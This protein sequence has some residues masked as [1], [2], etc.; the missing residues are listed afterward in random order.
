M[1]QALI[2]AL[3]Q[4]VHTMQANSFTALAIIALLW[5][6]QLINASVNYRLNTLGIVP[7]EIFGL[8]GIFTSP[9]LHGN[10]NHLFF[11]SI[12]L[13]FLLNLML[14]YGWDAFILYTVNI[15]FIGGLLTWFFGRNAT[16]IGCSGVIMGYMGFL[17]MQ[18]IHQR[19]AIA[20]VLGL[21]ALYY[22][23][24]ILL[25]LFP[26]GSKKTSWEGHVFGFVAGL[27]VGYGWFIHFL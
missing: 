9:F 12:P 4:L 14:A 10:A 27:M 11:N 6:I 19:T 17:M 8:S 24:S 15:A 3:G 1:F 22:C 25:S 2:T 7:R 13:F 21:V 16:H 18:A 5:F 20:L 23:S 26:S